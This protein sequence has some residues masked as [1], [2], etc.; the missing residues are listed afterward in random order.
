[1]IEGR[2]EKADIQRVN[3]QNEPVRYP[4]DNSLV[5]VG[6]SI[7]RQPGILS[8]GDAVFLFTTYVTT[9]GDLY[10]VRF[11]TLLQYKVKYDTAIVLSGVSTFDSNGPALISA[12]NG[13]D[14]IAM[15]KR[16]DFP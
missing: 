5:L 8:N 14:V 10:Y 7:C 6:N 13:Q 1:M 16:V 11:D 15:Q 12:S 2:G 4:R 9:G 3:N